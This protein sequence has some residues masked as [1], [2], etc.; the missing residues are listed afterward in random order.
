LHRVQLFV[1]ADREPADFHR[2][3]GSPKLARIVPA[4]LDEPA[5]CQLWDVRNSRAWPPNFRQKRNEKGDPKAAFRETPRR[6]Q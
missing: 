5:W 4:R 3:K 1:R 6:P 2:G